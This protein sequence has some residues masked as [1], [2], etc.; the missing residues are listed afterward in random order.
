MQKRSERSQMVQEHFIDEVLLAYQDGE[1]TSEKRAR[2]QAHLDQCWKCR[3]SL[4]S[5]EQQAHALAELF[6]DGS[7]PEPR[8]LVETKLTLQRR[9]SQYEEALQRQMEMTEPWWHGRE[10][11]SQPLS[12]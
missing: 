5:L 3:A 6:E 2:V 9:V 8:A 10:C 11:R 4:A 7:F 12:F 1:L